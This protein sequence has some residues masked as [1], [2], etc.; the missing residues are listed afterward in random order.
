MIKGKRERGRGKGKTTSNCPTLPPCPFSLPHA[1]ACLVVLASV[2]LTASPAGSWG[3]AAHLP[4]PLQEMSGAVLHGKIYLLGGINTSNEATRLAYRYDPATNQWERIADLPIERHHMPVV[5]VNDSLYAI[6]GYEPPTFTPTRTLFLYD[7]QNNL[8]L[9]RALLP[10]ARGASAAAA[11]SG[12][13]VVA[14]GIGFSGQLDSIAIYDPATDTW[15]H[16]APIPTLRD[17][18]TGGAVG[19]TFYAIAGRRDGNYDT[20]EAYDLA[21]NRWATRHAMPSKRGG[22]GS[23]VL[24]GMI[25]TYGGE[26]PGAYPNHERYDPATDTWAVLPPLPTPR[27]GMAVAALNG[28]IYVIAGGPKQGFA[29]TDVVEV[30]T[31]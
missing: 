15:R 25:Y 13:I 20:V 6:G 12:R 28:K 8:W 11:V 31:P 30:Y 21:A 1:F 18:L 17:H 10:E 27:H 9:G 2:G 24:N 19:A 5:V 22:L 29:Q 3:T 14:G 23:A 7:E 16:G 4:Q 26:R